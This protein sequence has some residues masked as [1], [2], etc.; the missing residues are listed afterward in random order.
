MK[1]AVTIGL[2]LA[3]TGAAFAAGES[4]ESLAD[5]VR[6]SPAQAERV[7]FEVEKG[8]VHEIELKVRGGR[9]VYQVKFESGHKVW[10]DAL[11]GAVVRRDRA[12]PQED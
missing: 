7:A 11:T 12:I 2:L 6:V 5:K 1:L 10:V 8:R 9:P 3:M 4:R